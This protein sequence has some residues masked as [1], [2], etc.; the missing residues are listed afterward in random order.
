MCVHPFLVSVLFAGAS[1]L[2]IKFYRNLF[3]LSDICVSINLANDPSTTM[4]R[5]TTDEQRIQGTHGQQRET[6]EVLLL[7]GFPVVR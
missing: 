7:I 6:S 2:V 4:Y 1:L 3:T 5:Q